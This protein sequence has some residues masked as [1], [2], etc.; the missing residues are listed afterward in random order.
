MSSILTV[1]LNEEVKRQ[2][3]EVLRNQGLSPSAAVQR[4]FEYVIKHD[5]LPFNVKER[6][7]E[8]DI[9]HMINVLDS[10]HTRQ[11]S[12]ITDEEIR[13]ARLEERYGSRP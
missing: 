3:T 6:P 5:K 13:N 7:E 9:E 12:E 2:G 4:L 1:R 11:S 10:F 8:D